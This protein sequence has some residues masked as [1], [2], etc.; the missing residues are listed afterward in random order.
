[1]CKKLKHNETNG[2]NETK[3]TEGQAKLSRLKFS[4]ENPSLNF[5]SIEERQVLAL[6]A[7][8]PQNFHIIKKGKEKEKDL[9][10]SGHLNLMSVQDKILKQITKKYVL[11][12]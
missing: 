12:V 1:M 2:I 7:V 6:L 4:M 11:Y 8:F 9:R 5:T 3:S 10:V